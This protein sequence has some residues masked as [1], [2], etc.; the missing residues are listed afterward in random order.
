MNLALVRFGVITG[1][2]AAITACGSGNS[3]GEEDSRQEAF[4]SNFTCEAIYPTVGRRE[5]KSGKTQHAACA[6]AIAECNKKVAPEGAGC[7]TGRWYDNLTTAEG[8]E[9]G[10]GW[11]CQVTEHNML[12]GDR[13]WV[14]PGLTIQEARANAMTYCEKKKAGNNCQIVKC[15]DASYTLP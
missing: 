4:S 9:S 1:W 2:V 14:R 12:P 11:A 5:I 7:L 3:P 8:M 15:F 6:A 13:S 10:Q